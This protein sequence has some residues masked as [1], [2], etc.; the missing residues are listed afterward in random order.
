[1]YIPSL[2]FRHA[3]CFEYSVSIVLPLQLPAFSPIPLVLVL[4]KHV[5]TDARMSSI[6]GNHRT[7]LMLYFFQGTR[8][9]YRATEWNCSLV[10]DSSMNTT[11]DYNFFQIWKS[12]PHWLWPTPK[13]FSTILGSWRALKVFWGFKGALWVEG[14]D[15]GLFIA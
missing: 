3:V 7:C 13:D 14:W 12:A 6:L 10:W 8:K 1:M 4:P 9:E 2:N 5:F 15:N 11:E